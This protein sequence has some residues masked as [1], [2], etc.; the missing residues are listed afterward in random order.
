MDGSDFEEEIKNCWK[1]QASIDYRCNVY[2]K[3]KY[4][5]SLNKMEL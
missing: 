1:Q 2:F 4:R 5:E 3:K